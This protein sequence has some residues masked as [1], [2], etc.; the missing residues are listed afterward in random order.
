MKTQHTDEIGDFITKFKTMSLEE[1]R[2]IP[3]QQRRLRGLMASIETT[4]SQLPE[5]DRRVLTHLLYERIE[6]KMKLFAIDMQ[7]SLAAKEAFGYTG[8]YRNT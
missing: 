2:S 1:T 4:I 7:V 6:S 8:K 3:D 5:R